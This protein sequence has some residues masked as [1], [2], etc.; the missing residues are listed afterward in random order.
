M[1]DTSSSAPS[2]DTYKELLG[3]DEGTHAVWGRL[4]GL[5]ILGSSLLIHYP[6]DWSLAAAETPPA[7]AL[8]SLAQQSSGQS[9]LASAYRQLESLKGLQ[10]DW[11]GY[12]SN[13][14]NVVAYSQARRVLDELHRV[15]FEPSRI[16][17]SADDGIAICLMDKNRY[18]D[19]ECYNS[20]E[21]VAMT[22]DHSTGNHKVWQLPISEM[23]L[24]EAV[25][26]LRIFIQA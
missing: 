5:F 17:A 2:P 23:G 16:M 10:P 9:W 12:G 25:D 11:N 18:A 15:N 19:L 20:G 7:K 6:T 21:V 4:S 13:P 24:R 3:C 26:R 22:T 1:T 8:F 14:P